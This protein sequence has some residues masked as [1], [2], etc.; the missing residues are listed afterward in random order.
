MDCWIVL[1][2]HHISKDDLLLG[3]KSSFGGRCSF[4]PVYS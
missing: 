2:F 4:N 1:N 3:C